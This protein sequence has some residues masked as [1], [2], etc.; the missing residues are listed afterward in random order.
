MI[1]Q[2]EL[3]GYEDASEKMAEKAK[4]MKLVAAKLEDLETAF[5][6]RLESGEPIEKGAFFP[7]IKIKDGKVSVKW[8][9]IVVEIKGAAFAEKMLQD[10]PRPPVKELEITKWDEGLITK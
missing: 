7:K 2:A 10:A 3:I 1:T 6:R 5:I 4:K 8:K 9:D